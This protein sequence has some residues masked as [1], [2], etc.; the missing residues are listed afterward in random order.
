MPN[1][2]P[3]GART[4]IKDVM[5]APKAG[6]SLQVAALRIIADMQVQSPLELY[7]KAWRNGR[8]HRDV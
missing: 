2:G 8:C 7:R 3:A 4:V 5:L 1:L 6:V